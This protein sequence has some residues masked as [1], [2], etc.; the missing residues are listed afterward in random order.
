MNGAQFNSTPLV[1]NLAI[2]GSKKIVITYFEVS[3][4]LEL[5][6]V[7]P[8]KEKVPIRLGLCHVHTLSA[9]SSNFAMS[10]LE[11][12]QRPRILHFFPAIPITRKVQNEVHSFIRDLERPRGR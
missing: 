8:L 11:V 3:C 6:S 1:I 12:D 9:Q 4:Y 5:T 10:F 2:D 7:K